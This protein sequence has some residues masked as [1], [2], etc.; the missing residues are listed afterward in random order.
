MTEFIY[1]LGRFHVLVVHLPIGILLLAA[2]ME[3]ARR[4]PRFAG[5]EPA[6]PIVWLAGAGTALL[7]VVVGYMHATE[8]GFDSRTISLHRWSASGLAFFAF[9]VWAARVDRP[10]LFDKAWAVAVAGTV[11]LLAATGHYGGNL[12]HGPTYLAEYA[13]G[14]LRA[15]AGLPAERRPRVTDVAEA[16]VFLD[17]VAPALRDRCGSCHNEARRRGE[18]VLTDHA[19]ILTGGESGA[20]VAPGDP[21]ASDLFRR[22]TLP[23][24]DVDYMPKNDK[25]PL[26][27]AEIAAVEWWIALGAP[28]SGMVGELAPDEQVRAAIA[29]AVGLAPAPSVV[30]ARGEETAS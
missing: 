18:L 26:T 29:E 10:K 5:L 23:P 11:A 13:P 15:M 30:S 22:V 1:Y 8:G 9:L 16:D 7:A 25:P 17:V 4:H 19:S 6:L 20:A 3:T 28:D 12:T 21:E 27:E 2:F 24:D 14:P